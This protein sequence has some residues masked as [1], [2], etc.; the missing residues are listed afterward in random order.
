MICTSLQ[1]KALAELLQ[2]L[3]SGV[4]EM[5]EIRLDLCPQLS[6]AD[7]KD[8]FS[9]S[10]VTLLAT[11]RISDKLNA[12][13]AERKLT[14]AIKAG[15]TFVDV[16]IEAPA[17]MASRVRKV[18]KE[19]A[20]RYIRSVHFFDG[21]PTTERLR[22]VTA[23]CYESGAEIA[24]IVTTAHTADDVEKTISLYNTYSDGLLIAF[25]MGEAGRVSR[26]DALRK[27]APFTYAALNADEATAAG[28]WSVA[29]M[30]KALYK[31][32]KHWSAGE[33]EIPASKSMAQRA[34]VAAMLA[35]GESQLNGYSPCDDSESAKR[36]V[37]SIAS[38]IP[39]EVF[40]GESGF[41][42]RFLI[43]IISVKHN[44]E[45]VIRGEKSLVGRPLKGAKEIM[46]AL[47]V[48]LESINGDSNIVS[49]P[50]K[51][52]GTLQSGKVTIS[53]K[54]GSQIISGLMAALPLL[55]EDSEVIIKEPKSIP[56]LK[57]T[58]DVL[59]KFGIKIGY[60]EQKEEI[61]LV[62]KGGQQY[63][64]ALIDLEA[65]WSGAAPFLI[66][67][68]IFSGVTLNHLNLD[69]VQADN[70]ILEILRKAGAR[71]SV[72]GTQIRT[73]K[74]P[75]HSFCIDLNQAPDLFPVVSVLAAFSHGESL[76][77]GME[78]LKVK[79]SDRAT[80]I[81]QML[82]QL[83]VECFQKDDT[84]HIYG[85]SLTYRYANNMLLG[86]GKF[87]S[88]ADHRMVMALKLAA[89]GAK[90]NIE[91]DNESCVSKSF[92][93]FCKYFR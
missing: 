84:L 45:T 25:C 69:S 60:D 73:S 26:M 23:D 5:A 61:K 92:P 93:D 47:G 54:D 3:D 34:I 81:T 27:G 77:K 62:V 80:A 46:S 82:K 59:E 72:N 1:N 90:G 70:L 8:L 39:P 76:L 7:I 20:C 38:H 31:N 13:E 56:Y 43:P 86:G 37:K 28:Q 16:E 14:L 50:L 42:T 88:N 15:A 19:N 4:V 75:L 67:G 29:D 83:G 55:R 48:E 51:V 89:E 24:K 91:I 87:T 68:A 74:S 11:C 53:G 21:T 36:V 2:I 30:S 63:K 58:I 40:V 41:L 33:I 10:P 71:V 66:A 32:A 12:D 85:K 65:D 35:G 44:G 9:K 49:V 17:D 22:Q 52:K 64:P 78:R 57:M 6:D 18:A 79:E